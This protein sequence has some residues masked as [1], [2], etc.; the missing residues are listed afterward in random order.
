ML[1]HNARP[2]LAPSITRRLIASFSPAGSTK[3]KQAPRAKRPAPARLRSAQAASGTKHVDDIALPPA[4]LP[5]KDTDSSASFITN[6]SIQS[7]ELLSFHRPQ[8]ITATAADA[9]PGASQ[10]SRE[11]TFSNDQD[12]TVEDVVGSFVN[13]DGNIKFEDDG[14]FSDPPKRTTNSS[15]ESHSE[16]QWEDGEIPERDRKVLWTILGAGT[17]WSLLGPRNTNRNQK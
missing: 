3:P 13:A 7:E 10:P 6:G 11:S 5:S 1:A 2:L 17:I 12:G 14:I 9:L 15:N 4:H 8:I 16:Y